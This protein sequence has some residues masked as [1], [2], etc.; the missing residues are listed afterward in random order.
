MRFLI[1]AV[2]R[3]SIA[4][5]GALQLLVHS[6]A[7]SRSGHRG[8][9]PVLSSPAI[10]V[11]YLLFLFS[12]WNLAQLLY[13]LIFNLWWPSLSWTLSAYLCLVFLPERASALSVYNH[14]YG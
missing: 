3:S 4:V 6:T 7:T 12:E 10:C 8:L 9:V 14:T 13:F 2:L 11:I 1:Y 5:L